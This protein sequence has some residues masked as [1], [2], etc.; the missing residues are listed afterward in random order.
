MIVIWLN[1][2]HVT[3]IENAI[4]RFSNYL[5]PI[6]QIL[7][8]KVYEDDLQSQNQTM[9]ETMNELF[10]DPTVNIKYALNWWF[11]KVTPHTHNKSIDFWQLRHT[12][13][14]RGLCLMT[15]HY[16]KLQNLPSLWNT[17]THV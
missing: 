5:F 14:I 7:P 6:L 15:C 8:L 9:T 4:F 17:K 12:S 11:K 3:F 16:K 1:K 10:F 13:E 2:E